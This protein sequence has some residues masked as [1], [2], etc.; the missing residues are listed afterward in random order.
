RGHAVD[1]SPTVLPAHFR[2]PE[3]PDDNALWLE[4]IEG[5]LLPEVEARALATAVD[6]FCEP[7]T[8]SVEEARHVI[9]AGRSHGLAA[10]LH[11]DQLSASGGAQLA[12]ELRALPADHLGHVS[13]LG[14]HALAASSTVA[15]LIPGSCFFVPTEKVPPVRR[16]VDAGVAIA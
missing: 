6:V 5:R 3:H 10:H 15:V 16:M 7:S 11:A 12:V 4:E 1:V 13:D 14:I 9:E 2:S 8:Y